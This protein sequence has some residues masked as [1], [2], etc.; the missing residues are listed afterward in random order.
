MLAEIIPGIA[1]QFQKSE[2][3][4]NPRPSLAGKERC[5]RQMVYWGLGLPRKPL[6]GRSMLVFDDS[7]WHEDLT[8]DWIRKTVYRL[9]SQQMHI[10]IDGMGFLDFI[11]DRICKTPIN[12]NPCGAV[13]PAGH[14]AGH[15]D[16]VITETTSQT[17]YLWEHKAINHF[18]WQKY[19]DSANPFDYISQCCIYLRGLHAVNPQI[20]K[21]ILLIKNKNTAQYLEFIIYYN[22]DDD[23]AIL[24]KIIDSN[25]EIRIINLLIND[26]V[27]SC[28]E[29]FAHIQQCV[30]GKTLPPREYFIDEWQCQ[31]CGWAEECWKNYKEEFAELKT[32]VDLPSDIAD[33][34]RYY[35]EVGGQKTHFEDEYKKLAAQIKNTLRDAGAREGR[36]GEYLVKLSRIDQTRVDNTKI[37][38]DILQ[39]AQ[40]ETFYE[41]IYISMPDKKSKKKTDGKANV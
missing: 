27:K 23:F 24:E 9:H 1:G 38:A 18:T 32:G 7:S 36:A 40:V 35:R 26:A 25:N 12:G 19:H 22:Y 17:D 13:I 33:T 10:N 8:A 3:R 20:D 31:Y 41:R 15:I 34:I 29:R 2:S 5:L 4:Y 21:A 37:P 11:P 6:P 39:A 28:L 16:G 30:V 14:L